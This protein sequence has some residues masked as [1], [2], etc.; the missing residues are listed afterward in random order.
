MTFETAEM[1]R[2]ESGYV[3]RFQGNQLPPAV[4]G[5]VVPTLLREFLLIK[6]CQTRDLLSRVRL[7]PME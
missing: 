3:L 2:R 7:V 5:S 1:E 6:S 4:A